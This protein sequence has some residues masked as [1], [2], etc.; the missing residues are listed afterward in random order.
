MTS[1]TSSRLACRCAGC[2]VYL[3]FTTYSIDHIIPR[4]RGGS[5]DQ[6]NLQ[7][8]CRSCNSSKNA[9]TMIEWIK[10]RKAPGKCLIYWRD[11]LDSLPVGHSYGPLLDRKRRE[12]DDK[13][14]VL[15]D[16]KLYPYGKIVSLRKEFVKYSGVVVWSDGFSIKV[17][18]HKTN[19]IKRFWISDV[20]DTQEY[21]Q[22][23]HENSVKLKAE[24]RA[25]RKPDFV[26]ERVA[27]YNELH[28]KLF[29]PKE[30]CDDFRAPQFGRRR[31][32]VPQ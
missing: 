29:P 2:G 20:D 17:L 28:N 9:R 19:S 5:N 32:P 6:S 3:T 11:R 8:M 22:V 10:G 1:R 23:V 24:P 4:I 16:T 13:T 21:Y 15:L 31:N 25:E 12:R 7:P 27:R 30:K 14:V 26:S 18:S